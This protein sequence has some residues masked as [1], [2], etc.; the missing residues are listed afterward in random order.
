MAND[1]APVPLSWQEA[2][3]PR[4]LWEQLSLA[5]APVRLH[6][7]PPVLTVQDAEEHWR[8]I[9]GV[10][11]K[12]LFLKDAKKVFWLVTLPHDRAVNLK[13][14]AGIIGS[15]K[16]SFASPDALAQVMGVMPGGVSPLALVADERRVVRPVLDRRVLAGDRINLHPMTNR[17]T[18]SMHPDDLSA[19]LGRLGYRPAV[20]DIA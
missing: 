6:I 12:N 16:L 4:I 7:H 2:G 11:T 14:L 17:A 10:H 9:D 8:G 18:L 13:D 15:A 20:V 1:H 3:I 5:S 19:L